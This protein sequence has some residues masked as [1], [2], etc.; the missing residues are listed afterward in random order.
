MVSPANTSIKRQTVA[1]NVG[2]RSES[3]M[4]VGTVLSEKQSTAQVR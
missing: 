3:K 1:T 4:F 2:A